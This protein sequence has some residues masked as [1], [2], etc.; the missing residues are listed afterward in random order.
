M[1][2]DQFFKRLMHLFLRE[3]FDLFFPQ[4]LDRLDISRVEWLE[5]EVFPDPP[6][7]EKRVVDILAK[8]PTIA[9]HPPRANEPRNSVVLIHI[10]CESSDRVSDFRERMYDYYHDVTK[11]TGMDVLP[12]AIFLRIGMEG[13]GIDKYERQVWE[14]MPL[15]FAYDY[16]GLPALDADRFLHGE[17]MLGVAWSCVMHMARNKKPEA[18]AEAITMIEASNLS[19]EQKM[20]LMDFIQAYSDLDE[21]QHRDLLQLLKDPKR[22]RAMQ[23]RKTWSEEARDEGR[24]EGRQQGLKEGRQQERLSFVRRMVAAKFPQLSQET[25]RNRLE[26]LPSDRLEEMCVQLLTATSPKDVGIEE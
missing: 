26:N 1:D 18:A 2:H 16:V 7:G 24:E 22:E 5:Q 25:I 10:E 3:F 20:T 12:I 15:Q 19:P 8:L 17:N 21:S 13:Q 23:F 4:W 11:R 9:G 14:R 6:R